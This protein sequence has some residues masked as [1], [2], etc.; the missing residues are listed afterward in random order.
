[1][2]HIFMFMP[3]ISWFLF[4]VWLFWDNQSAMY[5]SWLCLYKMHTQYWWMCSIMCY[6]CWDSLATSLLTI[7]TNGLWSVITHT[8]LAKSHGGTSVGNVVFEGL[9]ILY[10]CS[11]TWHSIGFCWQKQSGA[12]LHY[13]VLHHTN[14]LCLPL[15]EGI[16]LQGWHLMHQFPGIRVYMLQKIPCMHLSWLSSWLYDMDTVTFCTMPVSPDATFYNGSQ[17]SEVTAEN[18]LRQLSIPINDCNSLL[19]LGGVMSV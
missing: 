3:V 1:M 17:T 14:N 4:S 16:Q 7:A 2:A 10:C 5:R 8:S 13:W 19:Y 18:L 15:L 12:E 9:P 6:K 11:A